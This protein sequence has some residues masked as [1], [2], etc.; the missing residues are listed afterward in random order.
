MLDVGGEESMKNVRSAFAQ[1]E[2][3]RQILVGRV[4]LDD[5]VGVDRAFDVILSGRRKGQEGK[6]S[7]FVGRT[8]LWVG[9]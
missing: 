1:Q 5:L 3:A 2:V 9:F 4:R 8:G 6:G 7:G